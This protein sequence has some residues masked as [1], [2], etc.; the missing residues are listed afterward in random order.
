MGTTYSRKEKTEFV[1]NLIKKS[2]ENKKGYPKK[3]ILSN[4]MI[5]FFCSDRTAREIV[6]AFV[7]SNEAEEIIENE[8]SLIYG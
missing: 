3:M 8:E 4:L 6:Q 7:D 2:K 5:K 1:R